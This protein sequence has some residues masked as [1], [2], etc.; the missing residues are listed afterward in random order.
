MDN[1][2]FVQLNDIPSRKGS[3][4][5]LDVILTNCSDYFSGMDSH[6]SLVKTDHLQ[7][8][9]N[10]TTV[11]KKLNNKSKSPSRNRKVYLFKNVNS[12]ELRYHLADADLAACI[13]N[14]A[15]DID[16]AWMQ[17]KHTLLNVLDR[18]VPYK[19]LSGK[20]CK[21]WIDGDVVHA[22]HLKEAARRIAKRTNN[23][24]DWDKYRQCNNNVKKMV[25]NKYNE[26]LKGA[27]DDIDTH[28]KTFWSK[29][30]PKK[31]KQSIPN[32]ML[33]ND[34]VVSDVDVKAQAFNEFFMHSL[35]V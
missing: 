7:L 6:V 2:N 14:N 3:L 20:S 28:P 27:L 25:T 32:E 16:K 26:F 21:P 17:W 8:H 33:Y 12:D 19:F 11:I 13:V 29:V 31:R 23:V 22:S 9:F 30:S 18:I 35:I 15:L 34:A 5:V 1:Y 10:I 4:N 24:K